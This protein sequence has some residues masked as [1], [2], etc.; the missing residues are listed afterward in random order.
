MYLVKRKNVN[1]QPLPGE[2]EVVNRAR[3]R[4]DSQADPPK[5]SRNL[6]TKLE[7]KRNPWI[8]ETVILF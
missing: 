7:C 6:R 2:E 4:T 3:D 5:N 8:P 1:S